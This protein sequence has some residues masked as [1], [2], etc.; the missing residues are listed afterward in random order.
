MHLSFKSSKSIFPYLSFLTVITF[1]PAIW[2]DAGF[3]PW[4]DN[5]I[6]QIFLCP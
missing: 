1:N 6:K 4:A 5:G 3:V 2:A